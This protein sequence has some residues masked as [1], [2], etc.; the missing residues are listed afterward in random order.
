MWYK[1]VGTSLFRFITIHTF[2]RQ[3]DG[4]T[5]GWKGLRNIAHCITCGSTVHMIG[6]FRQNT[7]GIDTVN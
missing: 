5:D 4:R 3:R 7:F 6:S 1:N 2:D